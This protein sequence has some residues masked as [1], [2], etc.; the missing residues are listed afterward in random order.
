MKN[1]SG[2]YYALT[3]FLFLTIAQGARSQETRPIINASLAGTVID[4]STKEPIE[5]VTVQLE[6]V[7]HSVKTDRDG[8]FQFVTGQ[9]LPFSIT[10]SFLGY[11]KKTLVVSNSPTII[12]LVPNTEDLD[13]VVVV[14]YGTIRRKDLTGSVAS[15][16]NDFLKQNV[17]SLDQA[18]KGGVSGVQVTQTSGQPGGG[19]SIRIRGGASIQGGNEPLYVID[20]F[21]VYNQTESTG[22]GS[23][24]SIN[25]LAS[26]NPSDIESIEVLKDASAT[27]IYG[28]RGANGVV[29]VTT[30]KGAAG[31]AKLTYDGS[32]GS[33][34]VL[35]KIDILGAKDFALLRNEVLYDENPSLGTNQYLTQS[36]I[37]ALG[38]GTNWQNE[39]FTTAPIRNH[40]LSLTGGGD[41]VQYF[42]GA[43]Y[44]DQEGVIVNTDFK[45]LGFRSNI[46]AKPYER[47]SVGAN[48]SINRTQAQ[49]APS[50]IVNSL[51]IMPPTATVYDADGSY[52]LRNPFENIFANPI[53]TLLETT[54]QEMGLRTLGTTFAQYDI[55][56]GL[57]LKVLLGV[58]LNNRTDKYYVPSYI[59]EG[60]GSSGR[61]NLGNLDYYSW[62]NENT[63][64]Y[65][66]SFNNHNLNVLL[67][68]TQQEARNAVFGA[69]AENF[70]TDELLYNNLQSGSIL[71]RPTSGSYEWVLHSFLSRINYNY[72]NKYY[73]SASLRRDGS[74]RFGAQNKWGNFPS[75]AFSWRASQESF[76]KD[77]L[78]F[79]NDLKL[80]TSFGT[81]G[82]LEIG[83]YQS[84]STLYSLNYLIGGNILTGFASQ[85]IPNENLGWETTY[86]Y[87]AGIDFALFNSRL[88][89][90]FDWYYKKTEDLLLNVE[91]PWTSG[92]ASS[93][94]NYGSVQNKGVEFS[95]R[96]K[97]IDND[98]SWSTD[99]NLSFNRNK[100]LS[101]GS[102][103]TYITG[104]YII[105]VGKPLG[106]FYGTATDGIL[107]VGEEAEKGAFT[108]NA[109]PKAGDRLYRDIDGDGRFTTANDR[110]I[111]GNA[112]PDYI[113]GFTNTFN[114]KGFDLNILLQG[115]VGNEILNINR[116]NLEMFTGQQNASVDA[117]KRWTTG[118]PSQAYP[119]AKLDP[120]PVF[121]DQFV[122]DGSFVR[123]KSLQFGYTIPKPWI[124]RS[125]SNLRLYVVG[126]NLLTWTKYSG[127]DPEVTSG[128]NVQIGSDAGIYPA[129]KSFSFGASIT[130]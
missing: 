111:I 115:S 14:G 9:K 93:L 124:N 5:G 52:T 126:Q 91:I 82:N 34:R 50:G 70:V 89:F 121:S 53:A 125:L 35:K 11:E 88:Q 109:T 129:S 2:F 112:Q 87:D 29:L 28:S 51:L 120:A 65:N 78:P 97:N 92:Y 12:E 44:F 69:G 39:A 49:V 17:S 25:P 13:E 74:S 94:Q 4:A 128:S 60:S 107:Q 7:T 22:V 117:L 36:Q 100:V 40:Q 10:V 85:R 57:Q 42:L 73:A 86:Q 16:P 68:Y 72:Q 104:N 105:Q 116:Q 38:E 3:V 110:T 18:L 75:V 127:F 99:L 27:A 83:Q 33:Q 46:N 67:G 19:V 63:L 48:L 6:A 119:R 1:Y 118:N 102:G 101:I 123:L 47:L 8:K 62:L 56:D 96:S 54:N 43:N 80:R 15:L 59:Y 113:F 45:R 71:L 106:T 30:K 32:L 95:I 122:E 79:V 24:A 114:Y 103:T 31:R 98:F 90:T 66:K 76:I 20:G 37:D 21:P 108:G 81:T 55:L 26:I 58:D 41:Q 23:G 130:F 77:N 84:L 61:A 64:S